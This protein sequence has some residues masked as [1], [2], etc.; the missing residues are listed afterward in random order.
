[1]T[2][3]VSRRRAMQAALATAAVAAAP[4][5]RSL[6]RQAT[7]V[8]D[9][10]AAVTTAQVEAALARLDDLIE[11]ALARTGVPGAAVA[12]VHND[13]VV[14]ERGFGVRELGKPDPITP[15]TVFQIASLAKPISSTVVAAVVGDGLTSLGCHARLARA[16]VRA[17]RPVGERPD[18]PAR[19]VQSPL[20]VAGLWGRRPD[21]RRL[22]RLRS[23]GVACAGCALCPWRRHSAPRTPTTMWG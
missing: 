14:Y 6:A 8:A 17:G 2:M 12:V 21:Q 5:S 13:D 1:M 7:P 3:P 16:G 11:D 23:R 15:E 10:A 9:D 18:R 4:A 20:R 22:L 19:P